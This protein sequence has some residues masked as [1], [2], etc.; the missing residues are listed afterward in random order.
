[1]RFG[2]EGEDVEKGRPNDDKEEDHED[3]DGPSGN[4]LG[5]PEVEPITTIGC[6]QPIILNYDHDEEPLVSY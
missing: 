3:G 6:R 2:E 5:G 1:M 4:V